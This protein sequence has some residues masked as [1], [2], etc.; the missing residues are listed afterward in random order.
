MKHWIAILLLVFMPALYA[1]QAQ[2]DATLVKMINQLEAMKPLIRQAKQEQPANPRYRIH[3]D[4]WQDLHGQW[5]NGLR[6]DIESIQH[7]LIAAVNRPAIAPRTYTPI[8]GDFV[9]HG[10]V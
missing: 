2:M 6:Q 4:R 3:F 7:A 10:H 1:D 5:H 9:G 8:K